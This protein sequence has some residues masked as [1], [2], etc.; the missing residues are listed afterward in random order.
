MKKAILLICT[1]LNFSCEGILDRPPLDAISTVDYWKTSKDLENYV[2]QF[3]PTLPSHG[4]WYNGYGYNITDADDAFVPIPNATLTGERGTRGG[5]WTNEWRLVRAVNI[6]FDNYEKCEDDFEIYRHYLGEAHFFR[7][8]YYFEL[9]KKY[10]DVPWVATELYPNSG[11]LTNQRDTRTLVVDNLLNDLDLAIDYLKTRS[12]VGNNRINK[13]TAFAFKTR[14]GLF[15]GTWQ[16]YHANTTFGTSGAN[17]QKYFKACVDAAEA[18]ANGQYQVGL[19]ENYLRIFGLDDMSTVNEIFLYRAFN[20]NAGMSNDVQFITSGNPAGI[21]ITWSLVTSYLDKEGKPYDF[22]AV[23]GTSKGN[24]FLNRL[25]N[26]I[27]PRLSHTIWTPGALINATDGKTFNKPTIDQVELLLNPTG[28]Q[29]K[30]GSNPASPAVGKTGGGG[31]ETG[32]ILFR[33]G[34]VLLNYAEAL[35]ELNGVVASEALNLLRKRVGMPDFSVN[36][37]SSDPNWLNYGYP[38]SDELY[39]IRRERRVELALEGHRCDDYRRWAA[40]ALFKGERPKGYPFDPNEFPGYSPPLDENGLIDYY[41]NR[42][43]TGYMFREGR[44]YLDP[45]PNEELTLNP[46]LVQNPGW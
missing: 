26:D 1:L 41:K 42:L 15:E 12:E 7:A 22:L 33:Y 34:E 4:L 28:F 35:Y 9:V 46:A 13:E 19:Y 16:K 39:E 5:R 24:A 44:D 21:G 8:W 10:G 45:I 32:Y 11:D 40:H 3:Y 27:D 2:L 17:P 14:V 18:L 25:A 30:K 23:A 20:M 31:S 38:I 43:P 36:P 29:L 6:F 37:Q